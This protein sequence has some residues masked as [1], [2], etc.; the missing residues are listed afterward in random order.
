MPAGVA[1]TWGDGVGYTKRTFEKSSVSW[2]VPRILRSGAR[3]RIGPPA[4]GHPDISIAATVASLRAVD[5]TQYQ[6]NVASMAW[7]STPIR[8]P[9]I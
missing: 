7:R 3:E 9:D 4:L 1:S 5:E 2:P 8:A 6:E